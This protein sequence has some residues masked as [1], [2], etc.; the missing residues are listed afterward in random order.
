[1][2][3]IKHNE[4]HKGFTGRAQ[5]WKIV[6]SEDCDSKEEAS[7]LEKDYFQSTSLPL[8]IMGNKHPFNKEL[9]RLRKESKN[10]FMM[11]VL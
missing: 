5:D 6:F 4:K 9:K 8:N 3:L 7:Q 11:K 1:M 2:R 10:K